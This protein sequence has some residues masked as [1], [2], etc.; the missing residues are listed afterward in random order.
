ML[1]TSSYVEITTV[2]VTFGKLEICKTKFNKFFGE[3][4][5]IYA[6]PAVSKVLNFKISPGDC[7]LE[8]SLEIRMPLARS[9]SPAS[10][11]PPITNTLR[12]HCI[13]MLMLN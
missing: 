11:D 8:N 3:L 7:D 1:P 9:S 4:V 10:L 2:N 6:L 12:G 13:S 5:K